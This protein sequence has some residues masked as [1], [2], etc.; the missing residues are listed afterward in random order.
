LGE[1][2]FLCESVPFVMVAHVSH[3]KIVRDC[4][5]ASLSKRW[6]EG[7]CAKIGYRGFDDLTWAG[8]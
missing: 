1:D 8:C 2:L 3:P 5:P 4:T 7:V 6:I